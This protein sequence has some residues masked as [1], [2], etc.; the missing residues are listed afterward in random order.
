MFQLQISQKIAIKAFIVIISIIIGFSAC[1]DSSGPQSK[2]PLTQLTITIGQDILLNGVLG[3]YNDIDVITL[4]IVD[5]NKHYYAKSQPFSKTSRGNWVIMLK[6]IPINKPLKFQAQAY[7]KN[8]V[9]IYDGF[10]DTTLT[11]E[12]SQVYINIFP[13]SDGNPNSIP[14]LDSVVLKANGVVLNIVDNSNSQANYNILYRVSKDVNHPGFTNSQGLL[15]LD[16]SGKGSIELNYTKFAIG[17][18]IH[19]IELNNQ[20]GGILNTTFVTKQTSDANITIAI[21]PTIKGF[22]FDRDNNNKTFLKVSATITDD[23][24]LSNLKYKWTFTPFSTS[25]NVTITNDSSDILVMG[26]FD[27]SITGELSLKVTDRTNLTATYNTTIYLNQFNVNIVFNVIKTNILNN[28]IMDNQSL[29]ITFSK[30]VNASTVNASTIFVSDGIRV[31]AG[32]LQTI[33]DV[34]VFSPNNNIW[35]TTKKYVLNI[36]ADIEDLSAQ[37]LNE[38]KI[39]DF[40]AVPVISTQDGVALRTFSNHTLSVSAL[41]MSSD[42]KYLFSGSKDNTIKKWDIQTGMIVNRTFANHTNWVYTLTMSPDGM[43]MISGSQDASLELWDINTGIVSKTYKHSYGIYSSAYINNT[44]I[45]AGSDRIIS[46]WDTNGNN[47]KNIST[48]TKINSLKATKNGK[49]IIAGDLNGDIKL[50]NI[51]DGSLSM[52]LSGHTG[53]VNALDLTKDG[54]YIVSGSSDDSIKIWDIATGSL[55]ATINAHT[56][57]INALLI[58]PNQKYIVSGSS[59]NTIKLWDMQNQTLIRTFTGQ[60]DIQ[61]LAIS[62]NGK[63]IYSGSSDGTINEWDLY[64]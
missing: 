28:E 4:D 42:G 21:A 11:D 23:E 29:I 2:N 53:A 39:I 37:A 43:H 49:Y 52:T 9:K 40:E 59:D 61:S 16:S 30:E 46:I 60:L 36:K 1:S 56:N 3:G 47:V 44:H 26:N 12:N 51:T 18:F 35:N 15:V 19:S 57:D 25:A 33:K 54:K 58:T 62:P 24:N 31:V 5:N 55:N 64:R 34:V 10:S 32:N 14:Q 63:Y 48:A 13:I 8:D 50:Y 20:K 17:T 6:N 38:I 41:S 7:D 45:V 22:S 27:D